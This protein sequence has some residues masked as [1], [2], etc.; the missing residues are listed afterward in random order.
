MQTR[1]SVRLKGYDYRQSG[2]YFVTI[3]AFRQGQMFGRI[4]DGVMFPS[5][6]GHI[7]EEEWQRTADLRPNV[8]LDAFVLMPNH[9]HG[10][11][12]LQDED[13]WKIHSEEGVGPAQRQQARLWAG[14][15]GAII[16]RYKSSVTKRARKLSNQRGIVVW[17]R[18][19]H[20]H[21]IRN[22]KSLNMIRE[23]IRLNPA[24]WSEDTYF[25][26]A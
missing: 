14:S 21:I 23:Y 26:K 7:V 18:N 9:L 22:E 20:D 24:R 16:G 1:H 4:E 3:C 6:I 10:I 11:V 15:L 12:L 25:M 19:Y 17:Q 5:A 13:A 8:E 2:A